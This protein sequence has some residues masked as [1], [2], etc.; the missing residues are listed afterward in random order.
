MKVDIRFLLYPRGKPIPADHAYLLFSALTKACE[1]IHSMEDIGILPIVGM[2][3]GDRKL[4]LTESSFLTIRIAATRIAEILP[5]AGKSISLAGT[6]LQI[7]VPSVHALVSSPILKSRL[8]TIKG[9]MESEEFLHSVRVHLDK[10]GVAEDVEIALGKRRTLEI[11]G[12]SVVGYEVFLS[13]LS[14]NDSLLIQEEGLGGRR[15]LGC[16]LFFPCRSNLVRD[17]EAAGKEGDY[18]K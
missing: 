14:D 11:H 9:F 6:N 1:P 7:G 16:G 17:A 10:M 2:Q 13:N 3:T 15:K 5:L 18:V 12:K 8:V 4:L